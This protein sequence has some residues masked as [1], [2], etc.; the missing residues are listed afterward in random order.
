MFLINYF[1]E[2]NVGGRPLFLRWVSDFRH[3]FLISYLI[4]SQQLGKFSEEKGK[5]DST[6]FI[7]ALINKRD[8]GGESFWL[9]IPCIN[10]GMASNARMEK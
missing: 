1:S 2:I 7:A 5:S 4:F 9:Y 3:I 6:T 8:A 10:V